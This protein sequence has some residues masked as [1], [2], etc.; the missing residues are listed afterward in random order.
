MTKNLSDGSSGVYG[1]AA[2]LW[3]LGC[4]A[5]ELATGYRLFDQGGEVDQLL[6][7]LRVSV[8]IRSLFEVTS[9]CLCTRFILKVVKM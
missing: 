9:K 2:D 7:K 4:V 8:F 5:F 1:C 3:S 6:A